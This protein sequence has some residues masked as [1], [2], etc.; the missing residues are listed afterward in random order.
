[1]RREPVARRENDPA[2]AVM[3][4]HGGIEA[5]QAD[6]SAST[7]RHRRRYTAEGADASTRR[8]IRQPR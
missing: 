2:R 1:M 8:V 3:T 4:A 6:L 5:A 7:A